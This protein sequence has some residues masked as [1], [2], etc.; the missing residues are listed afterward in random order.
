MTIETWKGVSLNP[1]VIR[2]HFME[3][4]Q[5]SFTVYRDGMFIRLRGI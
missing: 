5:D 4:H 1:G 3:L 2:L